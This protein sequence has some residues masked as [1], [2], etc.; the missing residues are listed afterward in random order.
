MSSAAVKR[1]R[2]ETRNN[3]GERICASLFFCP[4]LNDLEREIVD[5]SFI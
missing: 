2:L 5:C 4:N 1:Q 3:N